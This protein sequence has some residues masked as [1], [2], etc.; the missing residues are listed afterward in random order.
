MPSAEIAN[1]PAVVIEEGVTEK[2]E[3]TVIPTEI[4]PGVI[5]NVP[6]EMFVN[7]APEKSICVTAVT[8]VVKLEIDNCPI[9]TAELI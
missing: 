6:A 1:V 3:G 8:V 5:V 4:T 9:P 2:P 7:V